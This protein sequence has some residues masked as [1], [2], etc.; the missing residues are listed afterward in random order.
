MFCEYMLQLYDNAVFLCMH[1]TYISKF[2]ALVA[3]CVL[4][5]LVC[6]CSTAIVIPYSQVEI[7][8]T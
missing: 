7:L 1:K 6:M 4:L 2:P 3:N 5:I 8:A